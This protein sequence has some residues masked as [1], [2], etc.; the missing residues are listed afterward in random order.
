M[1][2][3]KRLRVAVLVS[4]SGTNLQ[5]LLDQAATRSIDAEV[6]LVFSNKRDAPAL[7]RARRAGVP[8]EVL[9]AAGLTRE[10]YDARAAAVID[11]YSPGLLV[12]AGY[13]RIVTPAFVDHYPDRI[14]NIHP[15]LLPAFPGV[16]AQKQALDYGVRV[17]GCT[18]HFVRGEVDAGPVILQEAVAVEPGDTEETLTKRV[19]AREHELLP[20]TVQLFAQGRLKVEGRRVR[21]LP[22]QAGSAP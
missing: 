9:E 6:V 4:G 14:V 8:T 22:P 19:L 17:T 11:R 13:M 7:E 20:R 2:P 21:I 1:G 12:F 10:Q 15:A 18:T 5:A 3:A 16:H